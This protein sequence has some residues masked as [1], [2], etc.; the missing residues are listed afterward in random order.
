MSMDKLD[1]VSEKNKVRR[2]F[3]EKKKGY[4]V[5]AQRIYRDLKSNLNVKGLE[6]VRIINRYDISD[7]TDDEYM[8]SKNVIFSEPPV[9]YVYEENVSFSP[10]E[11]AFAIGLVTGQYDQ[12]ADSAAQCIQFLTLGGRPRCKAARVIVLKGVITDADFKKV[13]GYLINPVE[14]RDVG[15][16]KPVTLEMEIVRPD[17]ISKLEGFSSMNTTELEKFHDELGMAMTVEDLEFCRKYFAQTEHREPT[18]TE[19]RLIDTYWSDHCRHT[20]FLTKINDIRFDDGV[21]NTF[22]KS[23]YDMYISS[24]KYVYAD[25]EKDICLMDLATIAMKE[26]R[27]DG[28]L[29]DLDVSEEINACSIVVDAKVNGKNEE[30]LVM[31][32]NETH[33]HPTEIEPFG[34]ASTCLGGAIRDPL[35]GRS[36]V[37]QAMRV[38]GCADPR[39]AIEDTL[40]GKLPQRKITMDA[41]AGY[42]SYGNQIGLAAGQITEIYDPGFVAKRMELGALIAAAPKSNVV[43][44]TPE[45]GDI[46]ILLGG[47]TGRD[48]C[49][50]ATG[51]SKEHDEES[52]STCG[53]EVQKGNPLIERNI[54]RLF[55]DEN[56]SRMIKRCNDFGAGGVSVAIGELA[57]GLDIDLDS[58]LTKYEG[59]DG[60]ELAISESQERMAVVIA[61]DD[62]AKFVQAAFIE[63][64]EATQVAVVTD[65]GRLRMKWRNKTIVDISREFLNTNGVKQNIDIRITEPEKINFA[66]LLNKQVISKKDN[67]CEAWMTNLQRLENCSQKGLIERFDST[68]GAGTVLMPLG[69]KYQLS[70]AEGMAAKLPVI[71]GDT[72]T[73]TL[74]TFGYNPAISKWSPFHGAVF[75]VVEAMAKVVSMGGDYRKVR[76]TFQEYFEKPGK[77][78]SRWGKPFSALLGAYY[79]Q[80]K[81]GIPSIGGKDSMS[82]TFKDIDVPPTL[83]AFAVCVNDVQS[84]MS[85]EFKNAGS[86]V[87]MVNVTRD[88]NEL[89]DF[90]QLDRTYT[91]IHELISQGKITA[92]HSVRQGGVAEAISRMCFGNMIGIEMANIDAAELFMPDYGSIIVE[93]K[94]GED[95]GKI[96]EGLE[97]RVIGSTTNKSAISVNGTVIELKELLQG[98]ME[99]LENVFPTK[100][101]ANDQKIET[102]SF[103]AGSDFKKSSATKNIVKPRVFLPIFPGTTCEYEST[104]A[105][106]N[107]GAQ[108]DVFVLQNLTPE[109]IKETI[110]TLAEKIKNSQIVMFPGGTSAGDEPEGAGKLI[111]AIFANPYIREALMDLIK[112]R[113]G[114]VLGISN[115][116]QA[117]MKLGLLPYGEFREREANSPTLTFNTIGRHVSCMVETRIASNK[118]PWFSNVETGDIHTVAVS[119]GEGRFVAS[120][121][122]IKTLAANGQIAS[123]YVDFEGKATNDIRFN[124]NGSMFAIEGVT[125]PDGRILG[126]MGHSERK[127]SNV[128]INVP[129]NKDQM[130]FEAG[131]RYFR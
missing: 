33:N 43:R 54:Q 117:L 119:H 124:P 112:N 126:K 44:M 38:T 90:N 10:D 57:D 92:A 93:V 65:T 128:C 46:I 68:A 13:R 103:N 97:Y 102:F 20:T 116:F 122:M 45:S 3:T 86:Q 107:A 114:L 27:K 62:K 14:S 58:V 87:V 110:A 47:R 69:G 51:S 71:D 81:L 5:E 64:L 129:G 23:V 115:G 34:G 39:T 6:D 32:K 120:E 9:D 101:A 80:M 28:K 100:V 74:M 30:W 7:I 36:Y 4:D 95:A 66:E 75:A 50:G 85:T 48:G 2:I 41:A 1:S 67:L 84:M 15:M 21:F 130:L 73:G 12:R 49:G 72:D 17:D 55:R 24:R 88:S 89:P 56:V 82:G 19:I 91:R 52:L 26:L 98:W 16:D 113:D 94:Q 70:P 53:A 18:I 104:K 63:N 127:G 37:Y 61:K 131:V 105:F 11:K 121:E 123:Q 31:F 83:V 109:C 35:S 77:D 8:A 59:L 78:A 22:A 106:E 125:S 60:T 111:N 108:T 76:M 25:R 42:S 79:A 118:S 40:P 96:F 29:E 99:P